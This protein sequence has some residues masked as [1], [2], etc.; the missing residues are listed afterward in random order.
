M[1]VVY[2]GSLT[3]PGSEPLGEFLATC[4]PLD[5][6]YCHNDDEINVPSTRANYSNLEYQ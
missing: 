6:G 4:R 1:D 2:R 3:L 5:Y